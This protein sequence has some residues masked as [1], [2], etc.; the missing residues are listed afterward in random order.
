MT[1]KQTILSNFDYSKKRNWSQQFLKFNIGNFEQLLEQKDENFWQKQGEKRALNI[2]HDAAQRVPAYKDFLAK[3]KIQHAKIKNIEDFQ[4]IPVTNKKNYIQKY[5]LKDRCWNGR[6]FKNN[7][8]AISSGTSGEATFWPRGEYQEFETAVIHEL[9]Y[10]SFFE[11]KKYKTLIII[12]FPMGVYVSGMATV[13]P[14]LLISEKGYNLTVATVGTN[15]DDILRIVQ[16]LQKDY[17]Q[18]ILIGHPFFLKD[19]LEA[20]KSQGIEWS[21]KRLRMMFCSEGFSEKWRKYVLSNVNITL[22]WNNAIS[23][24][25]SSELLLMAYETPLSILVRNIIQ[26]EKSRA[27]LFLRRSEPNLFQ[28]NPL[29]RYIEVIRGELI[30]TSA[31]GIPLIRYNLHDSGRILSFEKVRTVLDQANP[32]WQKE[33][34]KYSIWQLPFLAM[35]GRS[36]Q[37]IVFY[38]ANIYPEHI[39]QALDHKPFFKK[40]TGKFT[41]RKDYTKDMEEFL[42]INIELQ[43]KVKPSLILTKTIQKH[44]FQRLQEIN[45]EYFDMSSRHVGRRAIP[46]I[47]L[48]PYQHPKYFKPG[49]KPRY[50]TK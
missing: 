1:E 10:Q 14:S 2:F 48:W 39:R 15:K 30:F 40:L 13:L 41:M 8:V 36:D 21:K 22:R 38:A 46:R 18:I 45:M 4:Q 37:T 28:Y 34:G 20:G 17:E 26:E 11:I 19:V 7:F 31:S 42:E 47:N 35:W 29:L 5:P 44:V 24:Y 3:Y 49:L 23:T 12:G 32:K 27:K 6:L 25:G 43:N 33:L 9:L 16:S 50:I